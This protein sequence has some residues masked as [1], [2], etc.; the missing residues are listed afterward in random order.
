MLFFE[1]MDTVGLFPRG[2][3]GASLLFQDDFLRSVFEYW[4]I[5]TALV[6]TRMPSDTLGWT[7]SFPIYC[8]VKCVRGEVGQSMTLLAE[9]VVVG[10]GEGRGEE[11]MGEGWPPPPSL[12]LPTASPSAPFLS[13]PPARGHC[14]AN[15]PDC[16]P[17]CGSLW[18]PP[19]EGKSGEGA[20]C[21]RSGKS[22]ND[23]CARNMTCEDEDDFF[24]K[25]QQTMGAEP[26]S[27]L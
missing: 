5:K 7:L 14:S 9:W 19:C 2:S 20:L 3:A 12:P 16:P 10:C 17:S 24:E 15:R 8:V 18:A 6:R 4:S 11:R 25:T 23:D 26:G 1:L 27:G 21:G 13:S 22:I